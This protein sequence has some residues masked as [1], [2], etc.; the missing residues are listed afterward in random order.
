VGCLHVRASSPARYAIPELRP[1]GEAGKRASDFPFIF[2]SVAIFLL[3]LLPKHVAA[4]AGVMKGNVA[5]VVQASS[6]YFV[7]ACLTAALPIGLSCLEWWKTRASRRAARALLRAPRRRGLEGGWRAVEGAAA[8]NVVARVVEVTFTSTGVGRGARPEVHIRETTAG[9]SLEVRT[10]DDDVLRI[11]LAGA[12]VGTSDCEV[13]RKT[14][15]GARV[16]ALRSHVRMNDSV[17]VAGRF[18][19]GA[20]NV[21]PQGPESLLVFATSGRG[22]ARAV[23]ARRYAAQHLPWLLVGAALLYGVGL[24]LFSS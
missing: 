15:D 13:E 23:L 21:S 20:R 8:E 18:A 5:E 6:S 11:S 7:V 3:A 2:A 1:L 14:V 24:A 12:T 4:A 9:R 10:A 19:E 22:S 17:L 16:L